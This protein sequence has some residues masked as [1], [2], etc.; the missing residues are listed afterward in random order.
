MVEA[1]PDL[2]EDVQAAKLALVVQA[3]EQVWKP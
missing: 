3:A 2:T 1:H